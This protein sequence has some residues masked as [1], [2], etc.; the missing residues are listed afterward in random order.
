MEEG[1]RLPLF[2]EYVLDTAR[3]CLLRAGQPV[4]LRPQAYRAL[5]FLTENRGRLVSKDRLIEEVWEGRAVT[6]D[7]LV[8]CLRDVRRALGNGER[9]LRNERGR[10]YI[11]ELETDELEV[12]RDRPGW[13]EQLD[14]I[15]MVVE[16]E[17]E[18]PLARS[19]A[20]PSE[21]SVGAAVELSAPH[22]TPGTER[23]RKIT[24]DKRAPFVVLAVLALG[25]TGLIYFTMRGPREQAIKS[26]AVLPFVNASG[27][28]AV[29]YVSDGLTENLI[30]ELAKRP[31]LKVIARTSSFTYKGQHVDIQDVGRA[32]GV[33]ALVT[34]R[35][36]QRGDGLFVSAELVDAQDRSRLWGEQYTRRMT[37][38]QQLQAEIARAISGKLQLRL[39]VAQ[40]R[41]LSNQATVN[42]QAYEFYLN[43]RSHVNQGSPMKALEYFNQAVLLD[44]N[45]AVAWAWVSRTNNNIGGDSLL[46]PRDTQVKA[47][48]AAERALGLDEALAD[49]HIALGRIK[50]D[51][52]DW[53]GAEQEY[54]RA[55]E[56]SPSLAFA[57][58]EYAQFLAVMTRHA[59]ALS[60]NKRAQELDPMSVRLKRQEAWLL[61]LARR[62]DEGITVIRETLNEPPRPHGRLG[63]MYEAKGL[64]EEAIREF[65]ELIARSGERTGNLCYLAGALA[66]AGKKKDALRI[67]DRLNRSKE[68]VSP[69]ELAAVYA[70]LKDTEATITLLE[71]A[72]A[73]HDPQLQILNIDPF[74]DFLRSDPRFQDLVKRV[75][76]PPLPNV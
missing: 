60:E 54:K 21:L 68:Y 5:K 20:A 57:H 3:G 74:F 53:K 15:R 33:R 37:D 71:K 63:F 49:A 56:L 38:L 46:N 13:T 29:A 76:L 39:S 25:V 23:F 66:V 45:F 73:D 28:P 14:L 31:G 55:I 10:G 50:Q 7:S 36:E 51:E 17:E 75:G 69:T 1:E 67:V 41:Q 8:Q 27:D 34:G 32:L 43:G 52:W 16:D 40:E 44:P 19:T 11:F 58:A 61:H 42:P 64:H 18:T 48:A 72:Y 65:R 6:D 22:T 47:K 62:I 59:E 2:G 4:H 12:L 9:Y 35:V 70:R 26:V 24:R 30:D